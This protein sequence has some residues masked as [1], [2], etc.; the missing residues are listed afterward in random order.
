MSNNKLQLWFNEIHVTIGWTM[1]WDEMRW[2]EM[3]WDEMRWGWTNGRT[4]IKIKDQN[5][6][7]KLINEIHIH[8]HTD[9]ING[10]SYDL[11]NGKLWYFHQ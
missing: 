9:T 1:G 5:N 3:R 2:D 10:I 11:I 6:R 8:R 7:I 4:K